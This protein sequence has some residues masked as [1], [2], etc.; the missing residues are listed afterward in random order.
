MKDQYEEMSLDELRDIA[1]SR[2]IP[3]RGGKSKDDLIA[4]IRQ[5]EIENGKIISEKGND[6]SDYSDLPGDLQAAPSD[7]HVAE[8]E[9]GDPIEV[10][11]PEKPEPSTKPE[12]Q[13][14]EKPKKVTPKEQFFKL[15]NDI[16]W[17][18]NGTMYRK[19]AGEILSSLGYDIDHIRKAGGVLHPVKD[20]FGTPDPTYVLE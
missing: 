17:N 11:K 4:L 13:T 6:P 3:G 7:D 5:F 12:V 15:T 1:T 10:S 9:K 16:K 8:E 20:R 14:V 18:Q 19:G 2:K